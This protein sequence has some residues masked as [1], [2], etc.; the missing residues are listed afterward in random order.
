M[1]SQIISKEG[2][3]VKFSFDVT[4]EKFEEGMK[5]SY[6]KNKAR[7][8]IPGFRKGKVPRKIVEA[9]FGAEM[10]YDDAVNFVLNEEYPLV[11][12]ELDLDVVSMPS[13]DIKEV[14]KEIGVKFDAEVTVKPEVKLGQYKGLEI[15]YFPSE[16][17]EEDIDA[18]FKKIQEENARLVPVEG[19]AA[20]MGDTVNVSYLGTVDGVEFEGGQSDSYDLKLGSKSFID[21]FEEQICGH[22]VGDKFDVNVTFPDE[23]HAE[24]LKGKAAVFAVE[25]ND[26]L[27]MELPELNDDF[28]QDVSDFDTFDEY[29]ASEVE[30][31]SKDRAKKSKQDTEDAILEQ[32]IAN[33]E[34][35][36][37]EIM[38]ENR[39]DE[40]MQEYE[41]N[42]KMQGISM[43][44][45]LQFSGQTMESIRE[46]V[47]DMAKNSVD[48]KL[49]V[50]QVV[51][52]E[53][54]EASEEDVKAEIQRSAD[55]Y[56]VEYDKIAQYYEGD[57]AFKKDVA[58]RKAV[59]LLV[60]TAIVK[61]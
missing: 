23:Y 48:A 31:L 59:K 49:V 45:Y 56:G 34:M 20:E 33:A 38:Y 7:I 57:E 28:A 61:Q 54:V 15:P 16:T 10:L 12:E 35:D 6:E 52:D 41:Q 39:V 51:K 9:Q 14:S 58:V 32:V 11:I 17:S 47:K 29:K 44:L 4:P 25:V 8:S 21:T 42:L 24:E 53:N 50:E 22:N 13:I 55:E 27:A 46:S 1:N 40:L 26:I 43:D 18:H 37:P 5:H 2:N 36:V 60:E 19:R 3:Q 30:K